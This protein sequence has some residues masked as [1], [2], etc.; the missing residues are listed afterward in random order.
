[1]NTSKLT[2]EVPAAFKLHPAIAA[3]YK[4]GFTDSL[5]KKAPRSLNNLP[6]SISAAYIAGG[7][8][9]I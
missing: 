7:M 6:L 1:M 9:A 3:S 5:A 4:L 8:D 2:I